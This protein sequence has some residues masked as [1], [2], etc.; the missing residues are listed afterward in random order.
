MGSVGDMG[1][2]GDLG[3]VGDVGGMRVWGRR[4]RVYRNWG[5]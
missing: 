4:F 2:M 5:V 3:D 1:C